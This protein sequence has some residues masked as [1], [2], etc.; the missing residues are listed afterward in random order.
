MD[1]Q[2]YH[3]KIMQE[4]NRFYYMSFDITGKNEKYFYC[5]PIG[6]ALIIKLVLI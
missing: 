1:L 3:S 6:P 5:P 4:G 2:L